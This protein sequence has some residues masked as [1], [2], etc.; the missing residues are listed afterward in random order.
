MHNSEI[1]L[2]ILGILTIT[3]FSVSFSKRIGLGTVIGFLIA[4]FVV[5]PSGF[6]WV[7]DFELISQIAEFG[8]VFLLFLIGL[9]IRPSKLWNMKK[10]VFGFGGVQV[11]LTA[12][13]I[14]SICLYFNIS[15]DISVLVALGL[16]LSSTAIDLQILT[17][18]GE[19][20]SIWGRNSFAVLLFQ[21][22][23]ALPLLVMLSMMSKDASLSYDIT[24]GLLKSIALILSV[25]IFGKYML[26]P[27]LKTIAKS[28]SEE[29]FTTA[30]VLLVVFVGWLMMEAHLPMTLGAFLA[31]MLLSESEFRHQI[32]ADILPFKA[33]LLGLF[34]MTIGMEIDL[35]FF[36]ANFSVIMYIILGLMLLKAIVVFILSFMFKHTVRD[37]FKIGMLLSQGGEFALILFKLAS[38]QYRIMPKSFADLFIIAVSIS[39][40]LTPIIMYIVFWLDDNGKIFR[41]SEKKKN[42]FEEASG[43]TQH[44]I[45]AGFGRVGK[46]IAH[47]FEIAGVPYVAL[48]MNPD[49][50]VE[51]RI[52][53]LPVFYGDSSNPEVLEKVGVR[54]A[55]FAIIALDRQ[56]IVKK[57]V[58]TLKE[59][60]PKVRIYAR[61]KDHI[62]SRYLLDHGANVAIPE[63]IE[64]SLFLGKKLLY[65]F[66]IKKDIV[67]DLLA[68]FREN[69]YEA[70]FHIVENTKN[71]LEKDSILSNSN[72]NKKS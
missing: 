30:T 4:G 46:T 14:F 68:F 11:F 13:F 53:G 40:F 48:D 69:S 41:V 24:T 35:L 28:R 71:V 2:Q 7:S 19:F 20:N 47:M 45:I 12:S 17:D 49:R 21:D 1:L 62:E 33:A 67:K 8:V 31:G 27:L 15:P 63:T 37:S 34:F 72:K 26:S 36:R 42:N 58:V 3:V 66:G 43:L 64:S 25:I 55:K 50:V 70:M 54:S 59:Y 39:M 38:T 23:M 9:E 6:N 51:G 60:F 61:A 10:S 5:G 65:D 22:I 57:T 52:Q 29:A 18:R 56:A 44:V 32:E 16:A